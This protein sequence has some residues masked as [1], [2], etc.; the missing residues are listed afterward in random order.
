[1]SSEGGLYVIAAPSGAGKTSLVNALVAAEPGM[2]ISVSFTTRPP[3]PGEIDGQHYHF[4]DPESFLRR[5]GNQ[6][7]LEHAEVFGHLYGTHGETT[8]ALL[9]KGLDVILEI[10]WQGAAQIR[11]SFPDCHGI[12]ILPPSLQALHQRL[13]NRGQDSEAVIEGRMREARA[14][15]SHC[16]EF[17][18]VVVNDDFDLALASLR[19]IVRDCREG[20]L[21]PRID[22]SELLAELLGNK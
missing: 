1:M 17:T 7:F 19:D 9:R 3:R 16:D 12:F 10:D 8:R 14:E 13:G 22:C 18:H 15:I 6:E 2:V 5:V 11:A 21:R 20:R 4:T